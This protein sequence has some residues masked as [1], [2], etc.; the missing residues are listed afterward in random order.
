MKTCITC[1]KEKT[2]LDYSLY[3]KRSGETEYRNVCRECRNEKRR[4]YKS[5]ETDIVDLKPKPERKTSYMFN[6]NEINV[7]KQLI[8]EYPEIKNSIYKGKIDFYA[9]ENKASR[10]KKSITLD[11]NVYESLKL[12]CKNKNFNLSD[13]INIILKKGLEFID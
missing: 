2:L 8:K 4:I 6:E 11:K 7:L 3:K 10:V 12:L 5:S 13:M 1:K 9:D